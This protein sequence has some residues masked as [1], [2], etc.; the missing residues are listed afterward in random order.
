MGDKS[1]RAMRYMAL[2]LTAPDLTMLSTLA[3]FQTTPFRTPL[4]QLFAGR[5]T[6]I[7]LLA[8]EVKSICQ[9]YLF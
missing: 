8:Y 2:G 6:K 9:P 3:H 4:E 7:N 1:I 5:S